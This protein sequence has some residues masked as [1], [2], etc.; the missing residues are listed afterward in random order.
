MTFRNTVS[1]LTILMALAVFVMYVILAILYESYLHPLTVLSTLLTALVGG[2]LTLSLFGEQASLY[3]A[4]VVPI[5]QEELGSHESQGFITR[6]VTNYLNLAG[7][8]AL[9][10]LAWDTAAGRDPCSWRHWG[11][12]LTWSG[13]LLLLAALVW[14][15][16]HLEAFLDLE[17][18]EVI[19][20]KQFRP[21]HRWYLWLSTLQWSFGLLYLLLSL[22]AWK[23]EDR[24]PIN[25]PV[26]GGET[27]GA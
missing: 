24:A 2:L 7:A 12:W 16:A 6:R 20:H 8:I 4:V 22:Q 26:N 19:D 1:D 5:G 9:A 23:A 14:L 17:V 10:P 3:A 21:A 15:H 11:R 13:M 18:R 25:A 27:Q